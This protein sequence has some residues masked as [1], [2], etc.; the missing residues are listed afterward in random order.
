MILLEV[1]K[2]LPICVAS[3]CALQAANAR[4]Q[5]RVGVNVQVSKGHEANDHMEVI[6]ATDPNHPERLIACYMFKGGKGSEYSTAASVS[7][8]G[9]R[10]WSTT[11]EEKISGWPEEPRSLDPT[12]TYGPDSAAYFAAVFGIS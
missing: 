8:D 9:G 11:L 3:A 10:T 5:I 2:L 6:G 7:F 4:P 12:C 1:R